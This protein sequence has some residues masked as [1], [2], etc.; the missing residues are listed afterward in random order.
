MKFPT[1]KV[2]ARARKIGTHQSVRCTARTHS[3]VYTLCT[4]STVQNFPVQEHRGCTGKRTHSQVKKYFTAYLKICCF[5]YKFLTE[6]K[7]SI[8]LDFLHFY[9]SLLIENNYFNNQPASNSSKQR[10]IPK[11][12]MIFRIF[13]MQFF[14]KFS[15]SDIEFT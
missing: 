8:N 12:S 15:I 1:K 3:N 6:L 10:E 4:H 13:R 9:K 7:I 2:Q 5:L 11:A 14:G